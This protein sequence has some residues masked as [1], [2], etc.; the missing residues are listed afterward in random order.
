METTF[1]DTI[2]NVVV[3]GNLVR[4]DF[5]TV[6]PAPGKDGT[7]EMRATPTLNMVMPIDGFIRA[8]GVQEQLIKKL[9]ADGVLKAVPAQAGSGD[10]DSVTPAAKAT[11]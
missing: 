11:N 8:F 5:G 4:F 7:Q 6:I 3:T 9:V 10:A 1:A 2:L